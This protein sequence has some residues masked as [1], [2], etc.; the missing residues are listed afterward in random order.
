MSIKELFSKQS[1]KI[2]PGSSM[3]DI[4]DEAESS[5]YIAEKVIEQE[6][7]IPAVDF[8]EPK[9]FV[10]YG[11]AYK[12]YDDSISHIYTSWPY[13]GS[14]KEKQ[15]FINS[16]SYLDRFILE[17]EYPRTTGYAKLCADGWGSVAGLS[18]D[19]GLAPPTTKEYIKF[20][21]SMNTGSSYEGSNV[22]N[23]GSNRTNNLKINGNTGN[24]VEFWMKKDPSSGVDPS[25]R[26]VILDIWNQKTVSIAAGNPYGRMSLIVGHD[27]HP[28]VDSSLCNLFVQYASGSGNCS[29]STTGN[30]IGA[31][32]C[33]YKWHH[34]A[35]TFQNSGANL[36]VRY[37]IDSELSSSKN[38]IGHA[39]NEVTGALIGYLGAVQTSLDL[40][41][42]TG[43]PAINGSG[44]F[45]G[46]I[47]DFRFWKVARSEKEIKRNWFDQ[48]GVMG[49]G[50]TNTDDSNTDLGIYYK[51]NEGITGYEN[52]D[53]TVLDYSG[54]LSNGWWAGYS[55]ATHRSTGSAM[56]E[57]GYAL[58]EFRDPIIYSV[59]PDVVSYIE[60]K[61]MTGS[62]YDDNNTSCLFHMFPDFI[63][64]DDDPNNDKTGNLQN[65]T[66]IIGNYFDNLYLQINYLP[67]IKEARYTSGSIKPVVFSNKLLKSVG[68]TTP[69]IFADANV[70]AQFLSQDEER[71]FEEKLYNIKNLIYQN[72]YNNLTYIYKSKGTEKAFRN[73]IRC[74]GVDD[75]LIK[76][77]LYANNLT[78]ELKDGFRQTAVKKRC[79]DFNNVD[80]FSSTV[81][82]C[83]ASGNSNSVS[84]IT[85]SIGYGEGYAEGYEA[86]GSAMTVESEII[87]PKKLREDAE[88]Y[89]ET[90]FMSASLFGAHAAKTDNTD[91]LTWASPDASN[92]QVYAVREE[93]DSKHAYFMLTG[94][95]GGYFP[96]IVSPL[97]KN[98]YDNQKWNFAVKVSPSKF[99]LVGYVTG[100]LWGD[101]NIEFIG[102]NAISDYVYNSF[103]LSASVTA[104]YGHAILITPK[105]L[106]VGAH[107]TNFVGA[108]RENTDV[109]VASLKYWFN[110]LPYETVEFHAK[111]TTNYGVINPYKNT[112]LNSIPLINTHLPETE[113]LALHWDFT[114]VTGSNNIGI[115]EVEDVSSGSVALRSRYGW[116]GKIVK[117]QHTGRGYWFPGSSADV[118]DVEYV[119]N[120][121]LRIPESL[122]SSDMIDILTTDNEVFT[123]ESRPINYYF[124]F[125]KSFYQTVSEEIIDLFATIKDFNNLIGNP[126]N[127]YRQEYKDLSKLKYLFYERVSN[128]PDI[129]KYIDFYKWID[130]SLSK[131]ILQLVPASAEMAEEIE[132]VIESHVLERNK[133]WT[134]FPTLESKLEEPEIGI[135]GIN[136]LLYPWKEGHAPIA[137]NNQKYGPGQRYNFYY[138]KN[139]ALR[140]D[141]PLSSSNRQINIGR[142]YILSSSL[143]T[144]NRSFTTPYHLET[145]ENNFI[146]GGVNFNRNKKIHYAVMSTEFGNPTQNYLLIFSSSNPVPKE[147]I[148]DD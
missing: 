10:H 106:Y 42:V 129:E 85:A 133:Y 103:H 70:M 8:S 21:G 57:S 136:E 73:L 90:P 141:I 54:R 114:T 22:Y 93:S 68:F 9:N 46:S 111:D 132:T 35:I 134:K 102:V 20:F 83:T 131:M 12:Y 96:K 66:Q 23:T 79:V 17:N 34:Y 36:N 49:A 40:T 140:T 87:F 60:Q 124:M 24:T 122:D 41:E 144:L 18:S 38:F 58:T 139:R 146:Y 86:S 80:R 82:Q 32:K 11:S 5:Y 55:S 118:V 2:L 59:H 16:S 56:I 37:Y 94:T 48:I 63:Q 110:N 89:F 123:R 92:F 117:N 15:Q 28:G 45:I 99:P 115:F 1:S 19:H 67:R 128:E 65:L 137:A 26:E 105:R 78:Y 91:D 126:V 7:F 75:E 116:A 148:E 62:W 143:Q 135:C 100:S 30:P 69:E 81:F 31:M 29:F 120:A 72:I 138:W 145:V 119:A 101:Y 52:I 71:V 97:Y 125:E 121:K 108:L 104:S 3:D 4:G 127:R 113:T 74:F 6:T 77:N 53:S 44:K 112:Y 50:G 147:A 76:L 130:S 95:V 43:H 109:Q 39:I 107:R 64:D 98:V 25:Y 47:D 88:E 142:N 27:I 14:L 33:D 13:D 84:F 61:H 51:F